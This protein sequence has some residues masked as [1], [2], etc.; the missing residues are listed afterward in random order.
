MSIEMSIAQASMSMSEFKLQQ[1]VD[2]TMIKKTMELQEMQ[3]ESLIS[4]LPDVAPPSQSIID[5]K[6]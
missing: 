5:V 2:L 4:N 1:A 3:I 6:V